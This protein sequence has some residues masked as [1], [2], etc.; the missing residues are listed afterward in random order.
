MTNQIMSAAEA[1]LLILE[2]QGNYYLA[3]GEVHLETILFS[4]EPLTLKAHI[5]TAP[6][7]QHVLDHWEK[8][9][10]SLPWI[11]N[12][13]IVERI[14]RDLRQKNSISFNA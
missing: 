4:S 12:E 3:R 6:D 5:E 8:I 2:Y 7:W 11:L 1:D 9:S 14:Q 10:G 13:K